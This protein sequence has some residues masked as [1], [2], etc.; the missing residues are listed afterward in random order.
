METIV[1]GC[2]PRYGLMRP[3]LPRE[4]LGLTSH[5]RDCLDNLR[6]IIATLKRTQNGELAL[7][8]VRQRLREIAEE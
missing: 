6:E 8:A 2:P 3:P 1:D 7:D 4:V 5:A